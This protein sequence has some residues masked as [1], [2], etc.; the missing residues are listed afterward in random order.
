MS[1]KRTPTHTWAFRFGSQQAI[2]FEGYVKLFVLGMESRCVAFL[3][4]AG[5]LSERAEKD[6]PPQTAP[7]PISY[8]LYP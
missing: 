4:L 7:V 8:R 3:G 1:W 2:C 6:G 5:A